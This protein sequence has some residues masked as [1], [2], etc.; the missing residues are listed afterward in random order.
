M[1]GLLL[2][3]SYPLKKVAVIESG[4][5][6]VEVDR[7]APVGSAVHMRVIPNKGMQ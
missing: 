3:Y 1:D 7:S 5:G 2:K 6:K 4:N